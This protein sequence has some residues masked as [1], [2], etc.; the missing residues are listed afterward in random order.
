MYLDRAALEEEK[1]KTAELTE[2]LDQEKGK[3]HD[4]EVE[5][6]NLNGQVGQERDLEF[7]VSRKPPLL[8]DFFFA[9][10]PFLK[11]ACYLQYLLAYIMFSS[12]IMSFESNRI[13]IIQERIYGLL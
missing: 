1:V 13:K 6:E 5:V 11:I 10:T 8:L 12:C 7:Q 9:P 2:Q 4:L 3:V